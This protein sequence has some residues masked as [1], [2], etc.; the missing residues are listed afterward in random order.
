MTD[1]RLLDELEVGRPR[2][3]LGLRRHALEGRRRGDGQR[4]RRG[5]RDR[6]R[7][8]G[9]RGARGGARRAGRHAL[10]GRRAARLGVQAV[11]A[12]RQAGDRP[13]RRR[14]RGAARAGRGRRLAAARR[15]DRRARPL[16][17]RRRG[18]DRRPGRRGLRQGHRR[19]SAPPTSAAR[20][21][22]AA[23]RR[24]CTATSSWSSASRSWTDRRHPRGGI[25][26]P[27]AVRTFDD[28]AARGREA[29]RVLRGLDTGAKDAALH[30]IADALL[31]DRD[32]ILAANADDV[33]DAVAS[34]TSSALVD[35]LTLDGAAARGA[36]RGGPR[37]GGAARPDRQ[38]RRRRPA[39]RTASRSRGCASRSA[40]CSWS[41]RRARTSRST[42]PACA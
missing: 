21:A 4:R 3:A 19:S 20:S 9:R 23:A 38:R 42:W 16:R 18:R 36:R 40:A 24:R 30:A 6:Q 37:G 41:T 35:R 29:A 27:M 26:R 12:L 5:L 17:R 34:G 31:A 10:R 2:L 15:R 32:A 25:L 33:A 14:R 13:H 7:R 8:R 22:S 39:A 11:A 1:H 28:L